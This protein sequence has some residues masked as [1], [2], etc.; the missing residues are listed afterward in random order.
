MSKRHY[1]PF[2]PPFL[3]PQ[4]NVKEAFKYMDSVIN[5]PKVHPIA[6]LNFVCM[7][8]CPHYDLSPNNTY[9]TCPDCPIGCLH[10]KMKDTR[11][12]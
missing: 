2:E 1:E 10:A 4:Y 5:A 7:Y 8:C 12:Y 6:A 3:N 11:K 9:C